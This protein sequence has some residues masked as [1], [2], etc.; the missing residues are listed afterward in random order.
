MLE[1]MSGIKRH[2]GTILDQ[3][4]L[5][6]ITIGDDFIGSI[7][8]R[9]ICHDASYSNRGNGRHDYPKAPVSVGDNVFLGANALVLMGCKIGHD[10]VIGA[11]SVLTPFTTV[12][13][14]EVWAGNPARKICTVDEYFDKHE[15]RTGAVL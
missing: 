6:I 9:I 11:G 14:G 7:G 15:L 8:S 13:D 4:Y 5:E 10:V 1:K 3:D 12:P 2:D